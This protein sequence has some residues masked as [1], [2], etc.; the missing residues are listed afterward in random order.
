MA[1]LEA[2][3]VS[4]VRLL[5]VAPAVVRLKETFSKNRTVPELWVKVPPVKFVVLEIV[6]VPEVEVKVPPSKVKEP[7][8]MAWEPAV[9]VPASWR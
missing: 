5:K 3:V 8:L 1:P 9:K 7:K 6:R 4:K 2:T